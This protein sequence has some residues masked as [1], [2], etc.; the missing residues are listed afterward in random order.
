VRFF[1]A[2]LHLGHTNIIGYCSRPFRNVAEMNAGLAERWSALVRPDDEVWV[3]GDVAMGRLPD[4]LET[5]RDLPGRKH[6]VPGNHDRCW[7][8]HRQVRPAD[9][10]MYERVGFEIHD[11]VVSLE[12]A[13]REVLA[14]HFPVTGDSHDRDRFSAH[15]P[16]LPDGTWLLHGHVHQKW[17]VEGRQVNVGVDVWDYRPVAE[18]QLETLL[19]AT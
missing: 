11:E 14:C 6:L 12:V 15:R 8:G 16:R 10:R 2:D 13:G 1:T 4:S 3:L 5:L 18:A 9:R 19:S 17:R 7:P